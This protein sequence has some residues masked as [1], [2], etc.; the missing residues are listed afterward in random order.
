MQALGQS[1]S[2]MKSLSVGERY[3]INVRKVWQEVAALAEKNCH[4]SAD[5][6]F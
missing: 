3:R 2:T 4:F 1:L 6:L 5:I